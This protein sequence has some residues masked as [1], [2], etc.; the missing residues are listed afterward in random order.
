MVLQVLADPGQGRAHRD[1]VRGQFLRVADAG[2]HQQLRRIDDTPRQNQLAIGIGDAGFAPRP[3]F[4]AHRPAAVEDDARDQRPD[5]DAEVRAI[6]RTVQVADRRTA[7]PAIAHR[8]LENAHALLLRAV[9]ILGDRKTGALAGFEIRRSDRV[10]ELRQARA[11]RSVAAPKGIRPTHPG[12]L[13]PEQRQHVRVRPS[14][15]PRSRPTVVVGPVAAHIGHGVDRRAAANN[16][17]AGAFDLAPVEARL[18]LRIVVPVEPTLR[19]Y[20]APAQRQVDPRVAI[21][22]TRLDQ[23]DAYRRVLAQS[24]GQRTTGGTG[25]DND[26]VVRPTGGRDAQVPPRSDDPGC[27]VTVFTPRSLARP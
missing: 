10:I 6:K 14:V 7:A 22:T 12:L 11:D 2:Q 15:Q 21:P 17:A 20:T 9:V 25:A 18:M 19:H 16:L 27:M 13:S 23:Q 8:H 26:V 24:A 4:D 3:V 5:R 1:T